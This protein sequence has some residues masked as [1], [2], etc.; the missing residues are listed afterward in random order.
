MRMKE[1][2]HNEMNGW[3]GTF[4]LLNGDGQRGW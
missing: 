4:T 1:Y 2:M 3:L